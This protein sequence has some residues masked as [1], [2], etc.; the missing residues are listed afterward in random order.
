MLPSREPL[1]LVPW[2]SGSA[3][4]IEAELLVGD[5]G[6]ESRA[7]IDIGRDCLSPLSAASFDEATEANGFSEAR[8]IGRLG[9]HWRGCCCGETV[10]AAIVDCCD[11]RKAAVTRGGLRCKLYM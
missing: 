3:N 2:D 9:T 7:S 10:A 4:M 8:L 6:P 11:D 5:G 1:R